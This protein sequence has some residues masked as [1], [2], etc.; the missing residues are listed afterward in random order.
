MTSLINH[1]CLIT[2]S[3]DPVFHGVSEALYQL[4]KRADS[5]LSLIPTSSPL[6]PVHLTSS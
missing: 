5:H 3:I 1:S 2:V 4:L 6:L